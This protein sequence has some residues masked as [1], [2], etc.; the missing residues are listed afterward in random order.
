MGWGGGQLSAIHL[1]YTLRHVIQVCIRLM[2]FDFYRNRGGKD[3]RCRAIEGFLSEN[4]IENL[5]STS[6]D[7]TLSTNVRKA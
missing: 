6:I 4:R 3:L 5:F 2:T 1:S 7:F